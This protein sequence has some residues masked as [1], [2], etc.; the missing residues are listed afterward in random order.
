MF[1]M[2]NRKKE[3]HIDTDYKLSS[4]CKECQGAP[5][6]TKWYNLSHETITF[7]QWN[8]SVNL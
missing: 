1:K 2:D 4:F 8:I 5:R 7:S 6:L 3:M